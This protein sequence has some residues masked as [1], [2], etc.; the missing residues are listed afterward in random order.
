MIPIAINTIH[1]VIAVV[2]SIGSKTGGLGPA[3]VSS[4]GFR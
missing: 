1:A 4:L 2:G 3:K